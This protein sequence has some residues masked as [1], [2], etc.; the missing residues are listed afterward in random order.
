M[1]KR[2]AIERDNMR[3]CCVGGFDAIGVNVYDVIMLVLFFCL[4]FSL[5]LTLHLFLTEPGSVR[6]VPV[7]LAE[8]LNFILKQKKS[9]TIPS[10]MDSLS[11]GTP[12][13]TVETLLV[14]INS[15]FTDLNWMEFLHLTAG[16]PDCSTTCSL[17]KIL[18]HFLKLFTSNVLDN[19]QEEKFTIEAV[20]RVVG[21]KVPE[22]FAKILEVDGDIRTKHT[23]VINMLIVQYVVNKVNS[24]TTKNYHKHILNYMV[25]ET[26]LMIKDLFVAL[27]I[28]HKKTKTVTFPRQVSIVY[29]TETQCCFK[30]LRNRIV[31][32]FRKYVWRRSSKVA[33]MVIVEKME[34]VFN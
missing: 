16:K 14:P 7:A 13:V 5:I 6:V 34:N 12:V 22:A 23:E 17:V 3:L 28:S 30:I 32:F 8:N 24:N 29:P 25:H 27:Q 1:L 11:K 26:K 33:P 2:P 20:E 10:R 19:F 31:G 4:L 15:L 9:T 18:G 21:N